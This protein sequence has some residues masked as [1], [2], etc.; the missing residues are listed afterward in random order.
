ML[1]KFVKWQESIISCQGLVP[2]ALP[3][4]GSHPPKLCAEPPLWPRMEGQRLCRS[5]CTGER[6][7]SQVGVSHCLRGIWH[8]GPRVSA[9]RKAAGL[10]FN[11]LVIDLEFF[12]ILALNL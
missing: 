8:C 3:R 9:F 7:I 6:L 11:A 4:E 12:L 2:E 1:G 10:G 5:L